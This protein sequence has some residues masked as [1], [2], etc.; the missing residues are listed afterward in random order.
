MQP[1]KTSS[2]D[3]NPKMY[4]EISAE[5]CNYIKLYLKLCLKIAILQAERNKMKEEATS[6]ST[7]SILDHQ[8]HFMTVI[9]KILDQLKTS[10]FCR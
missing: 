10:S 2:Q 3:H 7:S 1:Y 8:K 5:Y 6:I 9:G 4:Q